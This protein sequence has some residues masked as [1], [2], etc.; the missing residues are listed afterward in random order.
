MC[1]YFNSLGMSRVLTVKEIT[2]CICKKE[3]AHCISCILCS[4]SGCS[5]GNLRG[6]LLQQFRFGQA[7]SVSASLTM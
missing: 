2:S 4:T 1:V 3:I 7:V 5:A 6:S